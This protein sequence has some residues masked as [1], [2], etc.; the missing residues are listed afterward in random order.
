MSAADPA[1]PSAI[2]ADLSEAGSAIGSERFLAS[3]TW[4]RQQLVTILGQAARSY[5]ASAPTLANV[6]ALSQAQACAVV[7][8]QQPAIGGGPLYTLVKVAHAVAL[9]RTI[10]TSTGRPCVPVF[11]CASEDHDLGEAGHAD[12]IVRTGDIRRFHS[13]LG[14]GRASLRFRAA[15]VW[16]DGLLAHCRTH[17]GAGLG[18][19]WLEALHPTDDEGMGAWQCRM[20]AALFAEHGLVCIEGH[21]LRPL[22]THQVALATQRWP[23]AAL[24]TLRTHLL[25]AGRNDAFGDLPCAPLFADRESGRTALDADATRALLTQEPAT[26]SPGAALRPILQQAA[27]PAAAYVGGP[28]ELNYHAFIAPVYAALGVPAPRLV[29][30]CSL[31][32]VPSWV[33]RGLQRWQCQPDQLNGPP[34]DADPPRTFPALDALADTINLLDREKTTA[35]PHL[36]PQLAAVVTRLRNDH[37]RLAESLARATRRHDERPAWGS[38]AAYLHPRGGRQER[39]LSLFQALWEH[40]PGIAH[41]LVAAATDTAPSTHAYV[42]L[43]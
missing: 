10:T 2:P 19:A 35:A 31:S 23:T 9:A 29:P 1:V 32:L 4:D 21:H 34:P 14:G 22:W 13:D 25:A 18:T 43:R 16:W 20:L 39:T 38:L 15:T 30:R 27:L 11:W 37:R 5:D 3:G 40:G 36:R 42:S 24:A 26:L 6:R 41:R 28:G 12:L 7:T 8:G 33:E 17:L